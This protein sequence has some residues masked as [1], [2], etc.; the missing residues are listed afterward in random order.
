MGKHCYLYTSNFSP[1]NHQKE[2]DQKKQK[3][4]KQSSLF[5][6]AFKHIS[7]AADMFSCE[8]FHEELRDTD[9]LEITEELLLCVNTVP[10]GGNHWATSS[11]L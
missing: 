2:L 6:T 1:T 4:T 7:K 11:Y 10:R 9:T 5:L 8:V 3:Q